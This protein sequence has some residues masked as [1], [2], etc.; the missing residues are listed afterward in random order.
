[1]EG[2][3]DQQFLDAEEKG[4]NRR[5]RQVARVR[6]EHQRG[7]RPMIDDLHAEPAP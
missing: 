7:S 4:L 1:V 5:A 2:G 6:D 3:P